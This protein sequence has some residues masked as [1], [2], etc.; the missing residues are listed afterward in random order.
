MRADP[1]DVV[2]TDHYGTFLTC[3]L[4]DCLPMIYTEH[5]SHRYASGA[6]Q[7]LQSSR[8]VA[9]Q[10]II[11]LYCPNNRTIVEICAMTL[12]TALATDV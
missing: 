8:S 3:K 1:Q 12:P 6:E 10:M 11:L 2:C 7:R 4:P 5:F 9:H